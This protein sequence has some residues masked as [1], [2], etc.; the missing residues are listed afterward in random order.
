MATRPG[1]VIL[2]TNRGEEN[3][4]ARE[5]YSLWEKEQNEDAKWGHGKIGEVI[6]L[7]GPLKF[8]MDERI[9]LSG[10]EL[11]EYE[12]RERQKKEREA[13][14]QAAL[15]RSKRMLEADD[16]EDSDSDSDDEGAGGI[17]TARTEGANAFAGD[18]EDLRTMS[19]DIFVKGQQTRV[20][21]GV[22]G[23][24]AR[25]RMFPFLA[26]ARR[27][28]SYGEGLDIGQWVRKGREIEE[29]GETEEVREAK[30]RKLEE[31]EKAVSS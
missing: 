10:E 22:A 2:L 30:R 25:F 5:L 17:L 29:E 6:P 18:N 1:N 12:E 15:D 11:E 23:E 24:M 8:E 14:Q 3:T 21:R 27:V 13:A 9:P 28:D 19:F 31:E 16:L 20:G 7:Q 26:K 4:L